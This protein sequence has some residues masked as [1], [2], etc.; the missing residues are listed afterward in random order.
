MESCHAGISGMNLSKD[1]D[2]M[3]ESP[4]CPV[5]LL[6]YYTIVIFFQLIRDE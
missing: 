3:Y 4:V 5:V 6:Y 1:L 2:F